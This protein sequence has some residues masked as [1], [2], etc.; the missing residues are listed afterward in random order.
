MVT[1]F[2]R[3]I[4]LSLKSFRFIS[5]V[6][7]VLHTPF[8]CAQTI[9]NPSEQ[10]MQ[11]VQNIKTFNKMF[12]R[13]QVYLHFDNIGYFMGETI[14][15]KAYVVNPFNHKASGLSKVLYVELLTPEGR[16]LQVQKL[17]IENGQAHGQLPL[18]KLLHAGFYEIRS[19]TAYMLNEENPSYFS[20]VLPIFDAL[21]EPH[22]SLVYRSPRMTRPGNSQ[23]LPDMRPKKE[24]SS[25]VN[26]AFYPEG[27]SLVETLSSRVMFKIT[28]KNGNPA[29][30]SGNIKNGKG[31]ELCT[32]STLHDGMGYFHLRPERGEEYY[33]EITFTDDGTR[34][35]KLPEALP[36]GC[37][38]TVNNLRE[39]HM[40]VS[41]SK[42]IKGDT[43]PM[44]M[45][46]MS[47]GRLVGFE[48]I[49]W[50][51]QDELL[52]KFPKENFLPGILRVT[53]FDI[54]GQVFS[55][56][57]AFVH[58]RNHVRMK[59]NFTTPDTLQG[60][61]TELNMEL[62]DEEG[63]PH[64]S[65]LSL[66]IRDKAKETPC[67]GTYSGGM[68]SSLL[69]GS[70][71]KGYIHHADYYLESNDM[72]HRS[73]LDLL[74]CVQGWRN[75]AWERMTKP[76]NVRVRYPVEEGLMVMGKVTSLLRN[77]AK[78]SINLQLYL[79]NGAGE[80]LTGKTFTDK[81]GHF[82]FT[83][84]EFY[85]RWNMILTTSE[86]EKNKLKEMDINIHKV[87]GPKTRN[88]N[89]AETE[90]FQLES[91]RNASEINYR[92][93]MDSL[94]ASWENL[95]PE[96]K[97]KATKDWETKRVRKWSNI[98]YDMDDERM[99]MDDTGEMYLEEFYDW[100]MEKNPYFGYTMDW[101]K[102]S[103]LSDTFYVP[104]YKGRPV[105]FLISRVGTG[106]QTE[107]QHEPAIRIEEL[108]VNDVEGVAVS[109]KT[110]AQNFLLPSE[111]I[112]LGVAS[113]DSLRNKNYVVVSVF[114]RK[115]YFEKKHKDGKGV[116]SSKMDG[117]TR[118]QQFYVQDY[119]RTALP[120]D[121][122]IRRTLYWNPNLRTDEKGRVRI[123]FHNNT[124]HENLKVDSESISWDGYIN[125]N[126]TSE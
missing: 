17:K 68:S 5:L 44:G 10:L 33:A 119:S 23:R 52:L 1:I 30:T 75:H 96:V 104:S 116:R 100:L 89:H 93:P 32:F 14:W 16:V 87:I 112:A 61:M 113:H 54:N 22:D 117:Y 50:N 77:R 82:A 101:G 39:N 55:E 27:G 2:K 103:D 83:A 111:D 74:L 21:K 107:A 97:V 36:E 81:N 6:I 73:A 45:T 18:T 56:R 65:T 115:D 84:E 99:L 91:K 20:R 4:T 98:I 59:S 43:L 15:Y 8:V 88:Y 64:P 38:M 90:L 19:Y 60:G 28:D 57:P 124:P 95:L 49:H 78:D 13:E 66:S 58:P 122:T 120:N 123:Q 48:E 71:L 76:Q 40:T 72:A 25:K 41:L 9:G 29:T 42:N 86:K 102:A 35:F 62:T 106:V 24:R 37:V 53:L 63:N 26:M 118:P 69:L 94:E 11:F 109:E 70:E 114:V 125:F 47:N 108:S 79:Y 92:I 121:R 110:H 7:I 105:K 46:L 80:K 67:N 3:A 85:G 126:V 51:G 34:R 31:E 12:P